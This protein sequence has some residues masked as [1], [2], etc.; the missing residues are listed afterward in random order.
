MTRLGHALA[1][2]AGFGALAPASA[3]ADIPPRDVQDL[4]FFADKRPVF[5]RL[6]IQVDGQGFETRW[7]EAIGRLH[8]YLDS[9]GDGRLSGSERSQV[10]WL[11]KLQPQDEPGRRSRFFAAMT[12]RHAPHHDVVTPEDLVAFLRPGLGPFQL[13]FEARGDSGSELLF[14]QLDRD[15]DKKLTRSELELAESSLRGLD[16]DDDETIGL[17]ELQPYRNPFFGRA[18]ARGRETSEADDTPFVTLPPSGTGTGLVRRLLGLYDGP[19]KDHRLSRSEIGLEP[20]AFDRADLDADG[21]LD[22]DELAYFLTAITPNL[23]IRI[24]MAM[25]GGAGI[26]LV[27][28]DSQP[29][30]FA[31]LARNTGEGTFTLLLGAVEIEFNPVDRATRIDTR[32]FFKLRFAQSDLD[33]NGYLDNM[34]TRGSGLFDSETLALMDRDR[35]GK[36]F[37]RE[38]AEFLAR[39]ADL[40]GGRTSLTAIDSGR[41]FFE[42]L[43]ANG[44]GRLSLREV[45]AA[46]EKVLA[47]DRDGDGLVGTD[48]VPHRFRLGFGPGQSALLDRV[49]L[50]TDDSTPADP[51]PPKPAKGPA[52]FG[53]MDRNGDG[54]LSRREFLGSLADFRR[55]DA[56]R[57]GLLDAGEAARAK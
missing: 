24:R 22:T 16:R 44:D 13:R 10:S 40:M 26:E 53:K 9:D 57:D 14:R 8:K 37:E 43:D 4:V 2:L 11:E 5:L 45:R 6:H 55:L 17:Q 52:W 41:S 32:R 18:A 3:S 46:S 7:A 25:S 49:G 21:G 28:S 19:A 31:R 51:A 36:V 20:P 48:E 29:T 33:K 15:G 56:N 38:M 35:D 42:G 39:E 1:L 30:S 23:E 54:D 27:P 47:W 50:R 12:S 34:E